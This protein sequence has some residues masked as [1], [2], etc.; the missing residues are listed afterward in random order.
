LKKQTNAPVLDEKRWN[1]ILEKML[2]R[3]NKAN[4]NEDFVKDIWNRIHK[5]SLKLEILGSME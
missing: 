2:E 4:L 3:W 5:E 1:E